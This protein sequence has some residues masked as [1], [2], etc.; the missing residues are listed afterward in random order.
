MST[1]TTPVSLSATAAVQ[2]EACL[3]HIYPTGSLL[4]RR[5]T[6][7]AAPVTLGR[8][9]ECAIRVNDNS[10]SRCHARIEPLDGGY[11]VADC[12]STNGTL[13][14][15]K[16]IR[17]PTELRDGDSL[18]VGKCLYRF[19]AGGNLEAAYHEEIYRMTILDGLTQVH[20]RRYLNEFLDHELA[21][22]QRHVRP[23]SLML[24]DIDRFKA[25]ND[26]YGHL[27]GD[28]VLREVAARLR[29]TM[30]KG[31]LLA[32]YGGEE[33]AV[34]LPETPPEQAAEANCSAKAWRVTRPQPSR[35]A[36]SG[37]AVKSSAEKLQR[38]SW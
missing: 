8:G 5:Y 11:V 13:I 6:L 31:E 30:R 4:G 38:W 20:N 25:V 34:V 22:A 37:A 1:Q 28:A 19:L 10:V 16:R 24:F 27:C 2:T 17:Q 12:G 9:E 3:I 15:A 14:N 35:V 36:S 26:T 21:R 18:S 29:D 7:A 33:F 23:V 32:R